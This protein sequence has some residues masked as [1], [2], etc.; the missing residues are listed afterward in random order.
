[1]A[2]KAYSFDWNAL[3][4]KIKDDR[5]KK[6]KDGDDRIWNPTKDENGNAIAVI[7]FLPSLKSEPFVKTHGHF[8][9]YIDEGQKKWWVKECPSAIGKTCLVC[10]KNFE[11]WESAFES[12]KNIART[13][14]RSTSY[15]ANI[16]VVKDPNNPSAEGKV[17]LYKFGVKIFDKIMRHWMPEETDF[18][19]PEFQQFIAFDPAGGANFKL[20][21]KKSGDYPN[22]DDSA[23]S[24][25]SEFMEGNDSKIAKILEQAYDLNEFLDPKNFP[26]EEEQRDKLGAILGEVRESSKSTSKTNIDNDDNG[27]DDIDMNSSVEDTDEAFTDTTS[28]A[29]IDDD[30]DVDEPK[31]D[32]DDDEQFF[33]NL[34]K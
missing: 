4:Q 7:R 8:F 31:A 25:T 21:V 33:S 1:M 14:K 34:G 29:I 30:S 12:D 11:Y 17:F 16:Y 5:N 24:P 22:Y 6:K 3:E 26:T 32:Y 9:N 10:K 15:I 19:D 27:T 28:S 2:K 23:F 20:K 18:Q 13:R